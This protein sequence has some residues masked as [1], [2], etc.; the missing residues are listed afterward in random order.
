MKHFTLI[1]SYLSSKTPGIIKH[2]DFKLH[3][4]ELRWLNNQQSISCIPEG[5]Y[6]VKRDKT[7]RHQYYAVQNVVNRTSIEIHVANNVGH[8]QGCIGL[9]MGI[10][11]EYDLTSSQEACNEFTGYVGDNPFTLT[12]TRFDPLTMNAETMA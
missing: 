2:E 6:L 12:I 3:T 5:T 7:G 10:N 9:G 1:R 11:R 8:L 4:L